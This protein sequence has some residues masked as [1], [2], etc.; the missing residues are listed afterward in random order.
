MD[1]ADWRW[2]RI[3]GFG[4]RYRNSKQIRST[5]KGKD[6]FGALTG[7]GVPIRACSDFGSRITNCRTN[8]PVDTDSRPRIKARTFPLFDPSFGRD[9]QA[10]LAIIGSQKGKI[11]QHIRNPRPP[12]SHSSRRP[13][14][15]W[16]SRTAI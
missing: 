7:F 11:G 5:K 10:F 13:G 2:Q 4:I 15:P 8:C 14:R 6:T 1:Y 12:G 16:L 9:L 3:A